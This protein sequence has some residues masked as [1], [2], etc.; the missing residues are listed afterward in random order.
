MSFMILLAQI[1]L[2]N[3]PSNINIP[4]LAIVGERESNVPYHKRVSKI[5]MYRRKIVSHSHELPPLV[6]QKDGLTA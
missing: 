4:I 5:R 1:S 6:F 2:P 3:S